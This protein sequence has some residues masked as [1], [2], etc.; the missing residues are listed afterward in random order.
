M[1]TPGGSGRAV[2]GAAR[3]AVAL[4]L[5]S[6]AKEEAPPGALPDSRPPQVT[7]T[8]PAERAV[9]P[10][11]GGE[12]K[13]EFD[14][15]ID[16]P[17]DLARQLVGSPAY[18]Y[19]V[20]TGFSDIKIHPDGGWRKGAVYVIRVPAGIPDL[21]GNRTEE[22][23]RLLF[24]T[25]P[26]VTDTRVSGRLVDRVTGRPAS[27]AR[28]LFE[29]SGDTIPYT[30]PADSGATFSLP[31]LPPGRY[32]AYGFRDLNADLRLQRQLEAYDSASFDLPDSTSTAELVLRLTEPDTTPPRLVRARAADSVTLRLEFDDPLDPR[33]NFDRTEVVVRDTATG[34]EW[35]VERVGI[36]LPS[37]RPT[38]GDTTA[39]P[40]AGSGAAGPDTGAVPA[41]TIAPTPADTGAG[42]ADTIAPTPTD[43][44]AGAVPPDTGAARAAD[45]SSAARSDTAAGAAAD[46][47]TRTAPETAAGAAADTTT[48]P[49]QRILVR[50]GRPLRPGTYRVRVDGFVNLRKLA[51]GGDTTFVY[52]AEDTAGG[53]PAGPGAA[54]GG[55]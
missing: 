18:R 24:S 33:Q 7:R 48:L 13:I 11:L 51:G 3:L 26:P 42:P 4:L 17:S 38:A 40:T 2:R 54:G 5:A 53:R 1:R 36:T 20:S 50:L 43:T 45:T 55:R 25:G 35:P 9:V 44:G 27:D 41:D 47:A 49:S 52:P 14:E 46:T 6:C 32:E 19:R 15:P 12:V 31:A 28:V 23:I 30:A 37:A 34:R 39:R 10:D 29:R 8:E 21:L 16:A 22:P